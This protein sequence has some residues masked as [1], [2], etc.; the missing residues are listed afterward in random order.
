MLQIPKNKV[1]ERWGTLPENLR[2]AL[3]SPVNGEFIWQIGIKNHLI[4]DKIAIISILA[5]DV[6]FGFSQIEDLSSQIQKNLNL[7]PRTAQEINNEINKRIFTPL[8]QEINK[9][10]DPIIGPPEV[11][12]EIGVK[13]GTG[14]TE[15][16][17]D[18]KLE[19]IIPTETE[20]EFFA[21]KPV[22]ITELPATKPVQPPKTENK[23]IVPQTP[24]STEKPFV[25][26]REAEAKTFTEKKK[27]IMPIMGWFKKESSKAPESPVKVELETFGQK[28]EE[29]KEP[30][31]AKTETQKQRM[32]HYRDVEIPTPFGKPFNE[33]QNKPETRPLKE[34]PPQKIETPVVRPLNETQSQPEPPKPMAPITPATP[35]TKQPEPAAKPAGPAVINLDSFSVAREDK[36]QNEVKLEGNIINLKKEK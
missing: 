1:L 13:P 2:E 5:G 16:P 25:I 3:V 12:V 34:I 22:E 10:Y 6:L 8:L 21:P 9:V 18:T 14:I 4:E 27:T 31:V 7:D 17:K 15:T 28:I 11:E 19:S 20:P 32:V 33:I 35:I 24:I 30:A 23:P 26:H 36:N 29:K